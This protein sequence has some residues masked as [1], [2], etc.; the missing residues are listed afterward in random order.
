MWNTSCSG[1]NLFSSGIFSKEGAKR[2]Y[3]WTIFR[4]KA[5]T[6]VA[7]TACR[8]T[9]SYFFFSLSSAKEAGPG[10]WPVG[11][12]VKGHVVCLAVWMDDCMAGCLADCQL[13][14]ESLT[15]SKAANKEIKD[16][17]EN[18]W[19]SPLKNDIRRFNR[20]KAKK[21]KI[22]LSFTVQQKLEKQQGN[23]IY[24]RPKVVK[25]AIEVLGCYTSRDYGQLVHPLQSSIH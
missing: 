9:H 14:S 4:E 16:S 11:W 5:W 21:T 18:I 12:T 19:C 1:Q 15:L 10:H 25:K 2:E 7:Q 23:T 3:T 20:V 22:D 24:Q 8:R 13:A 6:P 17:G